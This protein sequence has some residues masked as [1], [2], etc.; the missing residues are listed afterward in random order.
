MT[1]FALGKAA[2][3]QNG[4]WSHS[5][6]D[7]VENPVVTPDSGVAFLPLYIGAEGEESQGLSIGSENY[8]CINKFSSEEDQRASLDFLTWLYTSDEGVQLVRD[9]LGF[10][11]PF[12]TFDSQAKP[13]DTLGQLVQQWKVRADVTNLPW[14]FTVFPG[15][16]FKDSFGGY[17][18][19]YALGTLEW[20]D[21]VEKTVESWQA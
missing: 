4:D 12:D 2:M 20:E 1:E 18:Q 8:L 11:A 17:L 19:Q 6:I 13:E 14:D 15:Q 9:E 3:V 16:R 5:Q 10:L 7:A 21:L